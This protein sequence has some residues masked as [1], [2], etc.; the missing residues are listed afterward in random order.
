MYI[1]QNSEG[2]ECVSQ[3]FWLNDRKN[4]EL[5]LNNGWKMHLIVC[6]IQNHVVHKDK[7]CIPSSNVERLSKKWLDNH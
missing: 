2:P 4:I 7:K 3:K 5:R 1:G 6:V